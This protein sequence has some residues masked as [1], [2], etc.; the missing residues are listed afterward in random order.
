MGSLSLQEYMDKKYMKKKQKKVESESA[1]VIEKIKA[2]DVVEKNDT[3]EESKKEN[4]NDVKKP[5]DSSEPGGKW[6]NVE[7]KSEVIRQDD[8]NSVSEPT[9]ELKDSDPIVTEK[10]PKRRKL[11]ES[12][13]LESRHSTKLQK[14][15][16]NT[17]GSTN[18]SSLQRETEMREKLLSQKEKNKIKKTEDDLRKD[19]IDFEDPALLFDKK[20]ISKHKEKIDSRFVSPSGGNLFTDVSRY[21]PNRFNIPPGYHW[22]GII[23]GNGFEEKWLNVHR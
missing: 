16:K 1:K 13:H 8:K 4:D 17:S 11:S 23:R 22:D 19:N 2:N 10:Q 3:H 12:E 5:I 9:K 7:T 18:K 21:P 20:V 6:I 15:E 14:I